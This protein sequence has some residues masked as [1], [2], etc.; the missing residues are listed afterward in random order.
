MPLNN[1]FKCLCVSTS[2]LFVQVG[3]TALH[4]ASQYG[5]YKI[6]QILIAC[7]AYLDL[8]ADVSIAFSI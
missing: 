6:V 4:L 5:Q 1:L 8:Q 7:K 3:G 2:T